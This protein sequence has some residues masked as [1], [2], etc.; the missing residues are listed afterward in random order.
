MGDE[1]R[2]M[3]KSK[4]ISEMHRRMRHVS[5]V[6]FAYDIA[7]CSRASARTK[8]TDAATDAAVMILESGALVSMFGAT[9]YS[10]VTRLSVFNATSS[11]ARTT[12]KPVERV[13]D[14]ESCE[15][16]WSSAAYGQSIAHAARAPDPPYRDAK[17]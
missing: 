11:A 14:D 13:V 7:R 6:E 16:E 15:S 5:Y 17:T 4:S 12:P 1:G 2:K 9:S 3:L 8:E 10:R